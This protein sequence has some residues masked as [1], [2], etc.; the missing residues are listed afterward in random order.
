MLQD[1][2]AHHNVPVSPRDLISR[3]IGLQPGFCRGR[4]GVLVDVVSRPLS[5]LEGEHIPAFTTTEFKDLVAG[6]YPVSYSVNKAP[7]QDVVAG[8]GKSSGVLLTRFARV[9]CHV[10]VYCHFGHS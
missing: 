5:A 9:M 6:R 1:V 3:A 4:N 10:L 2:V 7:S 8:V